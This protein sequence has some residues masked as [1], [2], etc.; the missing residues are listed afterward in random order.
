MDA[1]LQI[2]GDLGPSSAVDTLR[3]P[4][5][6]LV[7]APAAGFALIAGI[8]GALWF[9]FRVCRSVRAC[10]EPACTRS[11]KAVQCGNFGR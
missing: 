3:G 6:Q 5:Q 8:A 7:Q 2:V 9:R 11:T 4:I 10:D 1:V